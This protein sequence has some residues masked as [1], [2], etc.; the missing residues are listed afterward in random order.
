MSTPSVSP[1]LERDLRSEA[2]VTLERNLLAP[3][4]DDATR[5][6]RLLVAAEQF[7]VVAS[8]AAARM[9][10]IET[11]EGAEEFTYGL[12][13]MIA[14]YLNPALKT[15]RRI[16]R[17]REEEAENDPRNRLTPECPACSWE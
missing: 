6:E 10:E 11:R 4:L 2:E 14:D 15:A 17:E 13:D 1:Y 12:L 16:A 3:E 5:L 8:L 9:E 7:Q